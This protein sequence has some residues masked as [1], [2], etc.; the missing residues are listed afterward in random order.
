[1]KK[2]G[3]GAGLWNGFGGKVVEGETIEEGVRRELEEEVGIHSGL[4]HKHGILEF[5][6]VDT[7]TALKVH[8]FK[9]T[10]FTDKPIETDEMRPAWFTQADI[11]YKKMWADDEYWLPILLENKYFTGSFI[12]ASSGEAGQSGKIL[13]YNL[14]T[15]D[16]L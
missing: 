3:F 7:D 2:R 16:Y 13:E 12:F 15:T 4:L 10:H 1:M 6:Y 11:P 5:V 8:I 9:L 14:H